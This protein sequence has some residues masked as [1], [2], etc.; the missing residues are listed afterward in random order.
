M[1]SF[2]Q[3]E[4]EIE[5]DETVGTLHDKLMHLGAELVNETVALIKND[6]VTTNKQPELEEKS[7]SKLIPVIVK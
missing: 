4:I 5:T 1:K 3:K 7:A 6:R 2:L